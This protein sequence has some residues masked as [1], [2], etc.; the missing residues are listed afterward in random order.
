MDMDQV[1]EF[2]VLAEVQNFL[3]ASELL[4]ISQS[5]LSKHIKALEAEMGVLLFDR[6]TRRV[7]LT[8]AGAVFLDFAG[9]VVELQ[10]R[11]AARI[12]A[13]GGTHQRSL[14]IGSIPV[15]GPY[16]IVGAIGAFARQN[17][18]LSVTLIEGEAKA[19]KQALLRDEC[20]L[21]FV[22]DEGGDDSEFSRIPFAEDALA[23]V[24]PPSHP[25]A[26]RGSIDLSELASED[27]MLLPA[28]S[29]VHDLALSACAQ[30]GFEPN[31]VFT[32]E[33]AENIIDLVNEGMGVGL[34]MLKAA[35]R[36]V[37]VTD[38]VSVVPL[39]PAV[40]TYIKIYYRSDRELPQTAR[41]FI[42]SLIVNHAIGA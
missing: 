17:T 40:T 19:L 20:E 42:D 36:L 28:G 14:V 16:G 35:S 41:H 27:F 4:F 11:L 21:A 13:V 2:T 1:K 25:L 37:G 7:Q 34:L 30:A 24:L 3:R 5:S 39:D 29:L 31:V 6:S 18:D 10:Y 26:K 22:R 12:R 15:M 8:E 23:A 32:G 33:R 38:K 9:Q